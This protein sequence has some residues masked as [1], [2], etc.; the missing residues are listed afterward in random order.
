[1]TG[2]KTLREALGIP[3]E[4]ILTDRL[5][6]PLRLTEG[7]PIWPLLGQRAPRRT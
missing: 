1:M 7:K 2:G 3:P 6:R 5:N 4:T